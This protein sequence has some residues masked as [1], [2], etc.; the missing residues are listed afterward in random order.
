MTI[1]FSKGILFYQEDQPEITSEISGDSTIIWTLECCIEWGYWAIYQGGPFTKIG[2]FLFIAIKKAPYEEWKMTGFRKNGHLTAPVQSAILHLIYADRTEIS[3]N[4][5]F[6]Q[7]QKSSRLKPVF[8][9]RELETIYKSIKR[10]DDVQDI[11]F[12]QVGRLVSQSGIPLR[13]FQKGCLLLFGDS[14]QSILRNYKMKRAL[15][16]I[17]AEHQNPLN[18]GYSLGFKKFANFSKR[19][20]AHFGISPGEVVSFRE[21]TMNFF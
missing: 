16:L 14:L 13:R 5:L 15:E 19:F 18:V 11:L 6:E 2:H 20:Q 21:K 17:V 10:L 9:F 12:P 3:L 4:L 7:L 1:P 8:T